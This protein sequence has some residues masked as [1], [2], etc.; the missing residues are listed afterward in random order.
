MISMM[1]N[2]EP[3]TLQDHNAMRDSMRALSIIFTKTDREPVK[4]KLRPM[5]SVQL[6]MKKLR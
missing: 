1:V 6:V 5:P 3:N 4:S 2:V